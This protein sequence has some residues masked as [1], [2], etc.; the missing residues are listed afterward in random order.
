M[1]SLKMTHEKA[2]HLLT[3]RIKAAGEI[4]QKNYFYNIYYAARWIQ[5]TLF[6]ISN[7]YDDEKRHIQYFGSVIDSVKGINKET[8]LQEKVKF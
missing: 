2:I 3:E 5:T 6:V 7:L 8:E 1:I 4:P